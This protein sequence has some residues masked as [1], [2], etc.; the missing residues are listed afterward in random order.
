M[1]SHEARQSPRAEP[2]FFYGYIVVVAAFFIMVAIFGLYYTFGVFFKPVL[3]EFGWT[4][5]MTSGAFSL[6]AITQ[7]LLGIAMG[8]LTDR[9]GPRV[10]MTLCGFLL[11]LGYLLMSQIGA[12][13]QLYLFYGLIIGVGMGGSF[14]PLMS[15]VARWF[16]KRRSMATG[17]VAAGIGVG[18]LVA[19]PVANWLIST[20]DWRVSY[21]ILGSIVLVLV[22][23]AAQALRRDPA[24]LGQLPYGENK[25]EEHGLGLETD[26][27]SFRE[28]VYTKQLWLVS[29]MFFC[30]GFC[31]F[32]IMV[33]IVLHAIGLGVPATSAA[34]ILATIG[35]MSIVGRVV[36][37]SAADR[38][39]NKLALIISFILIAAALFWLVPATEAWIMYLFAAVFGFAYGGCVASQSPLVA[40]LFGLNSHGLILGF[41]SFSLTIGG[42]I[43]S[44]A[45][46][47][48]FDVADSY[49]VAF[50]ICAV[51]GVFGLI[52]AT[53]LTPI[54]AS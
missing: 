53:F 9:F 25:G 42:A 41:V 46:G 12:I 13:W 16:V 36:L 10:V 27:L 32:T 20:Y 22:I 11:G 29:G 15:T 24:Q 37:G 39:G 52:L 3:T 35:G 48:I 23:L 47:Y 5:A 45:A 14:V 44:F 18:T 54:K 8:G 49:Q 26:G 28:A 30:L 31:V 2:G 38:I 34:G 51:M 7:G 19:P 43:G 1:S 21:I 50:L 4:R 40:V 17:I 33:H 6:S